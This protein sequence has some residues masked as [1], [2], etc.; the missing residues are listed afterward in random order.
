MDKKKYSYITHISEII[1]IHC[2]VFSKKYFSIKALQ[3][4][5]IPE[6]EG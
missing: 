2:F 6:D 3:K 5:C 4:S 1:K